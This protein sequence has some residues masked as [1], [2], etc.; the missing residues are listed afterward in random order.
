MPM[1][2]SRTA[3]SHCAASSCAVMLI[4]GGWSPRELEGIGDEV[5]EELHQL[6]SS[7]GTVGRARGDLGAAFL[8]GRSR[9]ARAR[10]RMAL[11]SVGARALPRVPT[12]E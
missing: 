3:N 7:P 12:R 10:S 11:Q 9:L 1:P 8:D 5:L 6:D 4:T 2:L